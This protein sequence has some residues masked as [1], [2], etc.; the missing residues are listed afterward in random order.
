MDNSAWHNSR[1]MQF[2]GGAI[3]AAR[4]FEGAPIPGKNGSRHGWQS[5]SVRFSGRVFDFLGPA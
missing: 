3:H 4:Q 2:M 1:A 5:R